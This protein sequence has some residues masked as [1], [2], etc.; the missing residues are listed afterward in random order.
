[1]EIWFFTI[2]S[3]KSG[4]FEIFDFSGVITQDWKSL[5]EN[6]MAQILLSVWRLHMPVF[7][8]FRN[9]EVY[10][11][12]GSLPHF[13]RQYF[14]NSWEILTLLPNNIKNK[15]MTRKV[16]FQIPLAVRPFLKMQAV[17]SQW[18]KRA[19]RQTQ[20]F[21]TGALSNVQDAALP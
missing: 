12:C 15:I 5:L 19:C 14:L 3:S 10:T 6:A 7:S 11:I 20:L 4:I 1:M 18:A 8:P 21:L 13:L 16:F 2:F 17:A 9:I